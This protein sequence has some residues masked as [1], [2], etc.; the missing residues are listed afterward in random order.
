MQFHPL[1]TFS[2]LKSVPLLAVT[3]NGLVPR[4]SLDEGAVVMRIFRSGRIAIAD[5]D[6]VTVTKGMGLMVSLYPRTGWRSFSANFARAEAI[7][8]LQALRAAGA[9]LDD[10]AKA[11]LGA[12]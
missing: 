3:Y 7:R 11:A 2:G 6:K 12:G 4:L 9:P 5:L 8:F 10:K 1:A